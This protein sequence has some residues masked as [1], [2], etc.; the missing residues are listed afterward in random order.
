MVSIAVTY[1]NL[2]L[3]LTKSFKFILTSVCKA[4]VDLTE[5]ACSKVLQTKSEMDASYRSYL[6]H[7]L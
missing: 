5:H 2:R 7:T 4:S 3:L 6:T 1:I